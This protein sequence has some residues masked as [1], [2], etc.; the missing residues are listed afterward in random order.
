M[1]TKRSFETPADCEAELGTSQGYRGFGID[2]TVVHLV[3]TVE[4]AFRV[5]SVPEPNTLTSLALIV[6]LSWRRD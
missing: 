6:L 2:L 5:A 4:L 3:E 1:E